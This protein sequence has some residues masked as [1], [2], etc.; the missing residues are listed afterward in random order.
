MFSIL[1]LM[2]EN[3]VRGHQ[4]TFNTKRWV[5]FSFWIASERGS[6]TEMV[7]VLSPWKEKWLQEPPPGPHGKR[8]RCTRREVRMRRVKG[9]S[10]YK[11]QKG[12]HICTFPLLT[13]PDVTSGGVP[14]VTWLLSIRSLTIRSPF[15]TWYNC[16]VLLNHAPSSPSWWRRGPV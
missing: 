2:S 11:V 8:H 3:K 14:T 4:S 6:T 10:R 7:V 15:D 13:A 12:A 16:H 1:I 5:F 9:V